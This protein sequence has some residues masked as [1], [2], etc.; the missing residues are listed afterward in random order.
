MKLLLKWF[1][2]S[3]IC[4]CLADEW[5]M[6]WLLFHIDVNKLRKNE[7][8]YLRK[9]ECDEKS[10]SATSSWNFTDFLS[11]CYR[12][13]KFS[14][15]IYYSTFQV[16]CVCVFVIITYTPLFDGETKSKGKN[17]A[18]ERKRKKAKANNKE[19]ARET[20]NC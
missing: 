8:N 13:I 14:F 11:A 19:K 1:V 17:G 3:P 20:N 7:Q 2:P 5:R 16:V 9:T 4:V 10:S 6:L 18:W 12:K 15:K